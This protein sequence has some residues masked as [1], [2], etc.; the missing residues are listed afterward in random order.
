MKFFRRAVGLGMIECMKNNHRMRHYAILIVEGYLARKVVVYKYF[1]NVIKAN[2]GNLL[3]I[4]EV[5]FILESL[6]LSNGQ[7]KET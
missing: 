2:L 5:L 4:S 7:N 1:L 6:H 3:A